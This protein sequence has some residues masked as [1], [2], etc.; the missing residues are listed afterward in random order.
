MKRTIVGFNVV[1]DL[2]IVYLH[3]SSPAIYQI[4]FSSSVNKGVTLNEARSKLRS[5]GEETSLLKTSHPCLK[6]LRQLQHPFAVLNESTWD[7]SCLVKIPGSEIYTHVIC[8]LSNEN[9]PLLGD[10]HLMHIWNLRTGEVQRVL[11]GALMLF[12]SDLSCD[13]RS[14]RRTLNRCL[15]ESEIPNFDVISYNREGIAEILYCSRYPVL[16]L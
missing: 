9:Q 5:K 1:D 3:K 16:I 13:V 4:N 12:L 11:E 2:L 7:V 6:L 14:T 15:L 10:Q 8:A